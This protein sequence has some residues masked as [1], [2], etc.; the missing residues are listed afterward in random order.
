MAKIKK[1]YDI[2]T[3]KHQN[4][5]IFGM[6]SGIGLFFVSGVVASMITDYITDLQLHFIPIYIA[7]YLFL[8]ISTFM[9]VAKGWFRIFYLAS[10]LIISLTYLYTKLFGATA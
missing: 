1:L 7:V 4:D 3:E 9:M 5:I 10:S 6:L 2:I 8:V